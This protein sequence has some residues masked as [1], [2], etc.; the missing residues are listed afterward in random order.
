MSDRPQDPWAPGGDDLPTPTPPPPPAPPLPLVLDEGRVDATEVRA[1]GLGGRLVAAGLGVALLLG[2]GAFAATQLGG[3]AGGETPE[4][5]VSELFD[6]MG[7][8]DLLGM[9]ASLDPG[10]RDTLRRPVEDLFEE[11]ERL[12]VVD[13]SFELTGVPGLD[14]EFRDLAFRTEPILDGLARVYVTEGTASYRVDGDELP[15]GDFLADTLE[16]FEIDPGDLQQED[17][18]SVASEDT[19]LVA[20]ETSDGWRVSLGYTA[21]E[22]ARI[23]MGAPVPATGMATLGADSP[24]AAVEGFLQAAADVDVRGLVARLSPNELRAL[25]H[26]WPVLVEEADLPTA[27]DVDAEIELRDLEL[28]ADRDGDRAQVLVRSIGVDVVSDDFVGGATFADGCATL[29]GDAAESIE[30]ELEVELDGDRLCLDELEELLEEATGGEDLGLP[31][32][33]A[34]PDLG[35][36]SELGITTVEV[37]GEWYVA[38][39][40][41]LADAAIALL[42]TVDRADLEAAVDAVEE[43]FDGFGTAFGGGGFEDLEDLEGFEDLEDLGEGFDDPAFDDPT[44]GGGWEAYP[45]AGEPVGPGALGGVDVRTSGL[46][47]ELMTMVAGDADV[48]GCVLAELDRTATPEQLTQLADSYEQDFEPATEVQDLLFGAIEVCGG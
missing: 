3:T 40:A 46:V 45:G 4:A 23:S 14:L 13:G 30:E 32:L 15:V 28:E 44:L 29:R 1:G 19:F 6:A 27:E 2:G 16:R 41:T 5:A 47:E 7:D 12:E 26:Y 22:A 43:F 20:R 33:D 17:E 42:R 37:D 9:L 8:E 24:E 36:I 18:D 21:A 34:L 10:E 39:V 11:L 25:H 48:A 31:R 35:A 38:P